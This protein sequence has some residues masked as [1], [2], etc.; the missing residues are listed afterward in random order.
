[1][2]AS[3]LTE[4]RRAA[5]AS[6]QHP[7][8]II[9]SCADSRVPPEHVFDQ[10]LG[11]LFTVR[12]AGNISE[13]ATVASLEY[14]AAHLGARLIVVMGHTQCGA[15]KAALAHAEDTP[16][17]KELV[18]TIRPALDSLPKEATVDEAVVANVRR[19]REDL[20]KESALLRGLVQ[21][22]KLAVRGAVYDLTTGEVR[23]L[24]EN[25]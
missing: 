9:L 15:V 23:L 5:L 24:G 14:A 11:D 21:E 1:V 7:F 6:G 16:A 17:I 19:A 13:P 10:G 25:D 20:L 12:V 8:A 4:S 22:Q 2:N 18:A 3:H